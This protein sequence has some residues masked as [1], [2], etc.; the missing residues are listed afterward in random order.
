MKGAALTG[1]HEGVASL[2]HGWA[3]RVVLTLPLVLLLVASAHA[4]PELKVGQFIGARWFVSG[5]G[6]QVCTGRIVDIDDGRVYIV[7]LSGMACNVPLAGGTEFY[8]VESP[9]ED[10]KPAPRPEFILE[11][12][13]LGRATKAKDN[14]HAMSQ[15]ILCQVDYDRA[16]ADELRYL[17]KEIEG[18]KK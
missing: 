15:A 3:T 5:L 10:S 17:R 6:G 11:I 8:E 14:L 2:Y 18:L 9:G 7:R 16:V 12:D 1:W 4:Q 13:C